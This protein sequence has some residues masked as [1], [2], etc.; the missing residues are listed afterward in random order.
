MGQISMFVL[1]HSVAKAS[2]IHLFLLLQSRKWECVAGVHRLICW[3]SFVNNSPSISICFVY[4]C[5]CCC[6]PM[7]KVFFRKVTWIYGLEVN[8]RECNKLLFMHFYW[9]IS[10]NP[11]SQLHC[12][13]WTLECMNSLRIF[14]VHWEFVHKS[15]NAIKW[16]SVC[17][18]VYLYY[19]I[20]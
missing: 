11:F 2:H 5:C 6:T 14:S 20:Y 1:A 8:K 19:E 15:W 13:R 4:Y 9:Y 18:C 17:V 12:Y 10:A 3:N 7:T 16:V